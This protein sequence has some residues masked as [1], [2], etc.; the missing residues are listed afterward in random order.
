[1]QASQS[2]SLV[3]QTQKSQSWK[4]L[5]TV[6]ISLATFVKSKISSMG[7]SSSGMDVFLIQKS[8][9]NL[10][11]PLQN[12]FSIDKNTVAPAFSLSRPGFGSFVT[13]TTQLETS[14]DISKQAYL[15]I[16]VVR[17]VNETAFVAVFDG[18]NYAVQHINGTAN[19]KLMLFGN[20]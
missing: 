4:A 15:N 12:F 7:D 8:S 9:N 2:P 6:A 20:L 13:P 19:N 1:M 18:S 11:I 5:I 17:R 14:T 16:D 3:K 10:M